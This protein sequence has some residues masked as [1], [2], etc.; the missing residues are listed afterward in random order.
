ME[1]LMNL[2]QTKLELKQTYYKEKLNIARDMLSAKLEEVSALL[3]INNTL[4]LLCN[5]NNEI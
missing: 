4:A 1:E 2:A 3:A 5:R